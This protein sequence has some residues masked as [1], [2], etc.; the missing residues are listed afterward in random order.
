MSAIKYDAK[1]ETENN[2]MA[3]MKE[4][5]EEVVYVGDVVFDA[6]T[7]SN[8]E[9]DSDPFE[10]D[11]FV[12]SDNKYSID[13]QIDPLEKVSSALN[14][15]SHVEDPKSNKLVMGSKIGKTTT[16]CFEPSMQGNEKFAMKRPALQI[17]KNKRKEDTKPRKE[18]TNQT[19]DLRVKVPTVKEVPLWKLHSKDFVRKGGSKKVGSPTD[20]KSNVR[21]KESGRRPFADR[22]NSN[23]D[24]NS[25]TIK[26]NNIVKKKE[27]CGANGNV[28]TQ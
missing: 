4:E 10:D 26:G 27:N 25:S 16:T 20:I 6:H 21:K 28:K 11:K 24:A 18:K 14:E 13:D 22:F 7:T 1:D 5:K 19:I 2:V 8:D 12:H 23:T 9:D 15:D 17:E 3:E